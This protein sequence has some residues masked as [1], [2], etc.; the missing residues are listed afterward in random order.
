MEVNWKKVDKFW[1]PWIKIV[2]EDVEC[3]AA[4]YTGVVRSPMALLNEFIEG[5]PKSVTHAAAAALSVAK[6]HPAVRL[7]QGERDHFCGHCYW[8]MV[9]H[10]WSAGDIIG[11]GCK[12]CKASMG[13][14]IPPCNTDERKNRVYQR[15]LELY[16]DLYKKV[17][18]EYRD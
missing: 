17:P 10:G 6:W 7:T 1:K 9:G 14:Y 11:D 2:K 16:L 5:C 18:K 13:K 8:Q 4:S 12:T 3:G 15:L